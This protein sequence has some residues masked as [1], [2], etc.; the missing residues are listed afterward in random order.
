VDLDL[1]W[2]WFLGWA[3]IL[4][5]T[6]GVVTWACEVDWDVDVEVDVFCHES[7]TRRSLG[8]T[9]VLLSVVGS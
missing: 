6:F 7:E 3:F 9:A 2:I 8:G 5:F 4:A 1:G